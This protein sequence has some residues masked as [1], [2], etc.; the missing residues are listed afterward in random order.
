MSSI[1]RCCA[2][3]LQ[4]KGNLQI[5]SNIDK[6][7]ELRLHHI[8]TGVSVQRKPFLKWAGG[9]YRI[10]DKILKELPTG[11]RF[12]EPF[13]GSCAVYLNMAAVRALVC[14]VNADLIY[15][16]QHIQ[17]E[18]ED[19]IL[20]CKNFFTSENNSKERYLEIRSEFNSC[21][22]A[23]KRGALFLYL[24]RH[25]FN[26]LVRY[27][28]KGVFNV[29]FGKYKSP[30]FPLNELR[31][32][33]KKTQEVETS[34]VCCDFRST[35]SKLTKGDVVYCDPPYVPISATA[36]FTA[37]AGS[38]FSIQDQQELAKLAESAH[39]KGISVILSNH[40]TEITRS[41]YATAEVKLFDVQRFISCNGGNR[42]TAPE[43]LAIYR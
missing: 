13:A 18:G 22:D 8:S 27:N 12:V 36:N 10:I 33:Y 38:E 11:M 3:V 39:S 17:R 4:G 42:T 6:F 2:R 41:L 25:S 26:G 43:I 1:L 37:Y 5:E 30:Y 16:Y 21:T 20:Y 14:D 28:S 23:R 9:K 32:F 15:L 29:P 31:L 19:F 40:D 35:F 7:L 24:N 34:F